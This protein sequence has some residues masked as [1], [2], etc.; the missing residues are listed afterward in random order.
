MARG[1]ADIMG[2]LTRD[3][4]RELLTSPWTGADW[5]RVEE[6]VGIEVDIRLARAGFTPPEEGTSPASTF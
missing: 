5:R 1:G 6:S 4:D 2:E 3:V